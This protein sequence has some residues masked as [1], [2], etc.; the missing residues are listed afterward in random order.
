V[1]LVYQLHFAVTPAR[2]VIM[3]LQ[4]IGRMAVVLTTISFS[5]GCGTLYAQG[6]GYPPYPSGPRGGGIY[7]GGGRYID[8]A[9]QRGFD[10]GY[11]RGR[12]AARD[13]HRY[14]PRRE[15]RY[16]SADRGYDRRYGS[17]SEYRQLYRDGFTRGYDLGYRDGRYDRYDRRRW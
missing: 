3:R 13:G 2:S 6:R 16:R 17:R 12:E 11:E 8:A 15:G 4:P 7:G 14:N 1:P 5:I 10:D 9:Y